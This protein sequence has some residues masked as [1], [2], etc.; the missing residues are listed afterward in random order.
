M[1]TAMGTDETGTNGERTSKIVTLPNVLSFTRILLTPVFIWAMVQRRPWLAFGVFLLAGATDALDGYTARH[2]RLKTNLGL[3]LDPMGDK[4]LLTAAFIILTFP[5]WSVPNVL[6]L[7]LTVVCVGR[8]VLIALGALVFIAIR[9]RTVF[10][11]TLPGK[12]ST[13]CGV[14]VLLVVLFANGLGTSP[15]FLGGLYVLTAGLAGFS[16]IQY[17]ILGIRR[18]FGRGKASGA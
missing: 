18:F 11:P 12:A 10:P 9:G 14:M 16:G 15:G 3:W 4:V 17:V 5:R 13:I 7:W 1:G 6:P 2:F 8:D